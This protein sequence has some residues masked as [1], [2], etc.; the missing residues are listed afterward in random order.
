MLGHSKVDAGVQWGPVIGVVGNILLGL[1]WVL[2]SALHADLLLLMAFLG[3]PV[4]TTLT[5][6]C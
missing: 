3:V 1:A 6:S 2:L 5:V 4:C